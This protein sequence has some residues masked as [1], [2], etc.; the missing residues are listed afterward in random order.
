MIIDCLPISSDMDKQ[1]E[2]I[3][4]YAK[5]V[6]LVCSAS[7]SMLACWYSEMLKVKVMGCLYFCSVLSCMPEV[8][9]MGPS[10][11]KP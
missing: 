4:L 8:I 11:S 9:L 6:M 1:I 7:I 2:V 3:T 5:Q 10:L